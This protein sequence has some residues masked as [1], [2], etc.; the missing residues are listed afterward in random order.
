MADLFPVELIPT[1]KLTIKLY[2]Q[3]LIVISVTCPDFFFP[4]DFLLPFFFFAMRG[5]S[6]LLK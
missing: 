6:V 5:A 3:I 1:T 2:Y 4:F